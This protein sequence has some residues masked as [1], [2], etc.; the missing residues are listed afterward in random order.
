MVERPSLRDFSPSFR[1]NF[2]T[3]FPSFS[4]SCFGF[5]MLPSPNPSRDIESRGPSDATTTELH[6]ELWN[7]P[8]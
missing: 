4:S 3:I 6:C 1:S 2:E 5:G 8:S 7:E